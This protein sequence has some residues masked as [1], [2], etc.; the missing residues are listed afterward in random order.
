MVSR[1]KVVTA[2]LW[3]GMQSW[4]MNILSVATFLIMTRLVAPESFGQYAMAQLLFMVANVFI[5][6][7]ISEALVQK[8][9]IESKDIDTI[10]WTIVSLAA[11]FIIAFLFS[12]HWIASLFGEPVLVDLISWQCV[13][14]VFVT[15]SSVPVA[16]LRRRLEFRAVTLR[17]LLGMLTGG[18]VGIVM[19]LQGYGV[20]SLIGQRLGYVVVE[21]FVVYRAAKWWPRARFSRQSFRSMFHFGINQVGL[22]ALTEA[23]AILPRAL[24][25]YYFGAQVLGYFV[26]ARRFLVTLR[27]LT[28]TPIGQVMFPAMSRLQSDRQRLHV[29]FGTAVQLTALV[30]L[31]SYAG[32]IAVADDLIPW[33][34]GERWRPA[35][36]VIQ[37]TL[38]MGLAIAFTNTHNSLIR[39]M[40]KPQWLLMV[41]AAGLAVLCVALP[42]LTPY[43]AVVAALCITARHFAT[44]PLYPLMARKV[45]GSDIADQYRRLWPII[46]ATVGM[47][48]ALEAVKRYGMDFVPFGGHSVVLVVVGAAVY[49]CLLLIFGRQSLI[50]AGSQIAPGLFKARAASGPGTSLRGGSADPRVG[51]D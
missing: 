10:F 39:A 13:V 9:E 27:Q 12:R 32:L 35:V 17:T 34:I 8:S 15:L 18:I 30:A 5:V 45:A 21:C 31:P 6:G 43:G 33:L 26:I 47:V 50:A 42:L 49:G 37:A 51:T 36:P 25:G 20:W 24:I 40:G 2:T 44:L 4:G 46:L 11:V 22:G 29:A 16:L 1:R 3:S 41:Q 7:G 38:M 28:I 48:G 23:E 14:L 19:A